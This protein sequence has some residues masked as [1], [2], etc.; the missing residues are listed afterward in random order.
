M[1]Y[2]FSSYLWNDGRPKWT[3]CSPLICVSSKRVGEL[4]PG[5]QIVSCFC[6][7]DFIEA[8]PCSVFPHCPPNLTPLSLPPTAELRDCSRDNI[9]HKVEIF[10]NPALQIA[11]AGSWPRSSPW[12]YAF[13]HTEC[14]RSCSQGSNATTSSHLSFI[15][16]EDRAPLGS[17]Q[18][19][20]LRALTL[21]H[22]SSTLPLC[23]TPKP[24]LWR[25]CQVAGCAGGILA[26]PSLPPPP[27][28]VTFT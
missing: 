26:A 7:Q 16:S 3:F 25:Q 10:Y 21:P 2:T 13:P 20:A 18:L 5:G 4:Q 24:P 9:A 6:K 15:K 8:Q 11:C 1:C 28:L 23:L 17:S 12:L 27:L 22:P 14:T 19:T